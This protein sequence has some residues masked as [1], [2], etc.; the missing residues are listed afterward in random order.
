[1][2]YSSPKFSLKIENS[3][4]SS[5]D[6][7]TEIDADDTSNYVDFE[8][9]NNEEDDILSLEEEEEDILEAYPILTQV[10]TEITPPKEKYCLRDVAIGIRHG[11]EEDGLTEKEKAIVKYRERR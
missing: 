2:T 4:D 6:S 9:D 3:S 8:D 5:S 1:M 7:S 11:K 10:A